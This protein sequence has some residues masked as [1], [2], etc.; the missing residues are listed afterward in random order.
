MEPLHVHFVV[1]RNIHNR[2]VI[3]YLFWCRAGAGPGLPDFSEWSG[4]GL[5]IEVHKNS[6]LE[7]EPE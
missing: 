1:L 6:E 2:I 3:I 5:N 7:V 4:Y